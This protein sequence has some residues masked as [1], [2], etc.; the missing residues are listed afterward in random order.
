MIT[1]EKVYEDMLQMPVK[2]RE[3]NCSPLLRD[4]DLKKTNLPGKKFLTISGVHPL[5]SK[6]PLITWKSPKSH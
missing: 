1:A 3:K 6:K 5:R 2:E 4:R